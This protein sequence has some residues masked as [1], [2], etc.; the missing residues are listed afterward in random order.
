MPGSSPVRQHV[1]FIEKKQGVPLLSVWLFPELA[2]AAAVRCSLHLWACPGWE[3]GN[4]SAW[5]AAGSEY[6]NEPQLL[7]FS[8]RLGASFPLDSPADL[9][10]AG[11]L[12]C[13]E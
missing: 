3:W 1:L 9:P 5:D 11:V 12:F 6:G 10:K 8:P 4:G 7:Q 2:A 13:L